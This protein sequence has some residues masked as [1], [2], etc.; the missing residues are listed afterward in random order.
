M[1]ALIGRLPAGM[2]GLAIILPLSKLLGSYT[3]AGTVAASTMMGM[4]FCAPISGRLV[5]RHGQSKILVIFTVLNCI[6][7]ALL[8]VCAEYSA[9]L[10]VLCVTGV[11][12]GASR[13][14]TGTMARTRW[15]YVIPKH[16][17]TFYKEHL[18]TAYAF[19]LV[20]DE[21][22]FISAPIIVTLLCTFLHPLAGLACCLISYVGGGLAL[23][24]QYKT[25]P[26]VEPIRQKTASALS[27]LNLQVIFAAILF[28]GMSAGALEVIVVAR[29]DELSSRA[30]VGILIA[31]LAFSSMLSGFWYGAHHFKIEPSSL[32]LRC[33]GFL[34]L[35][36]IPFAFATD[37][38]TMAL[39]L[40]IAGIS[41]A[42]TA[43]SGQVLTERILPT[44]IMN[45]G[46]SII[47]TAMILGMALGG[48]LSGM[49][50]DK[51]GTYLAGLLPALA[52]FAAFVIASLFS[53]V[54]SITKI[55]I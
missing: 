13:L 5:D 48:W 54:H 40:F 4:A 15:A 49:L 44:A 27:N 37:A 9:P 14:S 43:I 21:V 55:K 30:L 53:R 20:I 18:Q 19:E 38:L 31:T 26:A 50:I 25:E 10:I 42:P 34:I 46:M 36:L 17:M 8:I 33:I 2:I 1:A 12:C 28:I 47:V 41:I 24:A 51:C 45:E 23:A 3:S 22:V 52:T 7:T 29:A 35:A 11:F 32:W 6:S 16:D 39:A